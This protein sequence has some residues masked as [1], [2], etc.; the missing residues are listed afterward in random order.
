MQ[1]LYYFNQL[2][3]K[4]LIFSFK[5][6]AAVPHYMQ[7]MFQPLCPYPCLILT[8]G[9]DESVAPELQPSLSD[10]GN[11][12]A[13]AIGSQAEQ[14]LIPDA[15]HAC[16]GHEQEVAAAVAGFLRGLNA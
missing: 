14:K 7:A 10:M 15:G 2:D 6:F 12:V 4:I 8:S 1:P 3:I 16:Q 9:A 13:A 5:L 11:R